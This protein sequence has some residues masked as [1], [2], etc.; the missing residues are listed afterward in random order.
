LN[1]LN[2]AGAAAGCSL[3]GTGVAS[4]VVMRSRLGQTADK[5]R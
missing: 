3:V 2:R 4:S 1:R 5:T